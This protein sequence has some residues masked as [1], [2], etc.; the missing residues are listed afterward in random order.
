MVY[1]V[2][3]LAMPGTKRDKSLLASSAD[4]RVAEIGQ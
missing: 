4:A 2:G 1:L 3:E